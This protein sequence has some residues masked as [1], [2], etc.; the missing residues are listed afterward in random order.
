MAVTKF[1]S[2]RNDVAFKRIFGSDRNK[3]ILVQFLNDM[4][5]FRGEPPIVDVSFLK[6]IQDPEIAAFKTCIVD[7]MC[8]DKQGNQYIVEMQVTNPGDFKE[9]VQ[10]YGF[11]VYTKQLKVG[12]KYKTSKPVTLIAITDFPLFPNKKDF[13]SDHA[14]LDLKTLENDLDGM[15]FTFLE[16]P[17][18]KKDISELET[19]IDKWAYFFKHAAEVDGED[20]EKIAADTSVI[21]RAYDEIFSFNWTEEQLMAYE[22]AARREETY[23][24]SLDF[25]Y[26]EGL[27]EGKAESEAKLS[28]AKLEI[29]RNLL[30]LGLEVDKISKAS[31]L[32]VAEIINLQKKD[33]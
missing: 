6:T 28:E 4:L 1:L 13:K 23:Y 24:A 14:T 30:A 10:H 27:A 22:D 25:R 16:L 19:M 8:K 12:E 32:S 15:F 26:A 7:V 29:A 20:L 9:R 18:F 21:K 3:D 33:L 2:P 11:S 17:K 31:G 5:E